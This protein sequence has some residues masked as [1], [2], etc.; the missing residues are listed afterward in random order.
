MEVEVKHWQVREWEMRAS[1]RRNKVPRFLYEHLIN[2]FPRRP[3][4]ALDAALYNV[5][6][7]LLMERK[8]LRYCFS[9]GDDD[10]DSFRKR[11]S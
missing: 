8:F 9:P 3:K 2:G 11:L 4:G 1:R 6:L 7:V 5:Y 10:M